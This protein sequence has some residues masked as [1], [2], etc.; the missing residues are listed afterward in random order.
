MRPALIIII[1]FIIPLSLCARENFALTISLQ[2]TEPTCATNNGRIVVTT[3]GGVAPY[4]YQRNAGAPQASN[5]FLYVSAATHTITVKDAMGETAITNVT[6]VNQSLPPNA[7]TYTYV[8]PSGCATGDG[9]ITLFGSGGTPPYQYSL[10]RTHFQ[11]DNT[12]NNMEAGSFWAAVKDANGCVNQFQ[13]IT[14]TIPE[15]CPIQHNGINMSSVCNPFRS[16]LG[17]IN[18][19][20]GTPPYQYSLDG[21]NWQS[22]YLFFPLPAGIHTVF[23]KDAAGT[24]MKYMVGL[25]DWCNPSFQLDG[26]VIHSQCDADNGSVSVVVT[27]GYG[28]YTYSIDGVNFQSSSLFTGLAPGEYTLTVNDV[29][30]QTATKFFVV[31]DAGCIAINPI[32]QS[33]SCGRANGSIS[34]QAVGGT[35]PYE[36]AI[37]NGAFSPDSQFPG[38]VANTYTVRVRDADGTTKSLSVTVTDIAGPSLSAVQTAPATCLGTDGTISLNAQDGTTPYLYSI[39][40]TN[41]QSSPLFTGLAPN[42]YTVW[43]K[44]DHGCLAQEVVTV[45]L[46]NNLFANAGATIS[47]C[48]GTKTTLTA[49]SNGTSHSWSPATGL[50][51]PNSLVTEASPA[52]ST[53]YTY[54]AQLGTCTAV[55]KVQITVLPAPMALAPEDT[56]ICEGKS[57]V[58]SGSGGSSHLWTPSTYLD[59]PG[60]MNPVVVNPHAGTYT[61]SLHVTD[62]NDCRSLQPDIVTVNVVSLHVDAGRDTM[63]QSGQP[64]QL[65]ARDIENAGF[66]QYS[67]SPATGLDDPFKA[68]PVARLS[69]DQDYFVTATGAGGC[70]ATDMVRVKVFRDIDIFVPSA[71][72]PNHDGINDRLKA[73][74]VGIR[75]FRHFSIY[76]RWGEL[77]FRTTDPSM[78]WD[79]T[80]R[81][82]LQ[83]DVHVWYAEGTDYLGNFIRRKGT[84]LPMR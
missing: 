4:T 69:S 78:G 48:E 14:A 36:Y 19:S 5:V 42:P 75:E 46:S 82:K 71:F 10:D 37:D 13:L 83:N 44:D 55:S 34:V 52:S 31:K 63:V 11:T 41:F 12:W 60:N 70:I 59:D 3:S 1:S 6:L 47:I 38:L 15:N 61:Y 30:G 66:V 18:V 74:P 45:N 67:W 9:S 22:D 20:G 16:Y 7:P 57:L 58:L 33:S 73:I 39:N 17:L 24:L 51:S 29:H 56:T 35:A 28:P 53:E 21:I 54:T 72:T 84:V 25:H 43:V 65:L 81:G 50:S 32:V 23:V 62:D 49:I 64:L 80:F 76:N 68:D 2:V 79:G 40:G 27:T 26:T 77:V 8:R